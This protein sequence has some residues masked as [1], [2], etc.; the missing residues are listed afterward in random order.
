M[1]L[2]INL[3][4]FSCVGTVAYAE[5]QSHCESGEILTKSVV[6]ISVQAS[7]ANILVDVPST[8]SPFIA[9]YKWTSHDDTCTHKIHAKI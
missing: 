8:L 5:E 3:L 9:E 2:D 1:Y 4:Q 6:K 7:E